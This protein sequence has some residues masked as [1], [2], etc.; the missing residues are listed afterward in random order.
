MHAK[1]AADDMSGF[2]AGFWRGAEIDWQP[3][4]HGAP[5][6]DP[7]ARPITAGF[8]RPTERIA[9]TLAAFDE[10]ARDKVAHHFEGANPGGDVR[11]RDLMRNCPKRLFQ[12]GNALQRFG[13]YGPRRIAVDHLYA[14]DSRRWWPIARM[15]SAPSVPLPFGG[16]YFRGFLQ[17]N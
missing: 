10:P 17:T 1:R 12:F 15:G 6:D 2:L 5:R 14:A 9:Q 13:G 7:T 3:A 4:L 8:R 11:K 16:V